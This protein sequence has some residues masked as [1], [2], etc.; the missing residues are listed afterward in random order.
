V[1]HVDGRVRKKN[2]SLFLA[3]H[4]NGAHALQENYK[5]LFD[6]NRNPIDVARINRLVADFSESYAKVVREIIGNS[7][8]LK[9]ET[10]RQNVATLL[11]P[12]GM[13]RVGVFHGLKIEKG[14]IKDPN[15][16]LDIC[17]IEAKNEL[18]DLKS[19]LSQQFSHQRSRAILELS[20]E[21]RKEIVAE[22]SELFDKLEWITVN[23][24]NIG[25][26]GAS[27]ILFAVLPEIALPVDKAEWNYVFRTHSYGK[28]LFIM[29]DEISEWEQQSKPTHLETLD[30]NPLTTLTSVYNVMAMEAREKCKEELK[31]AK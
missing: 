24:S 2:L 30:P 29:I 8:T 26:V 11:P 27:K 31:R 22:V 21:T 19:S 3:N 4:Q 6:E 25:P 18:L 16:V 20:P 7:V 9:R 14:I 28:L 1:R 13:T 17:W 5:V 10:F 15:R 23:G 12:F